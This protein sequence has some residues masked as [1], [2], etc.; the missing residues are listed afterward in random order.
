MVLER[1]GSSG[2]LRGYTNAAYHALS[3]LRRT[4]V[5]QEKT[6]SA[7]STRKYDALEA[8]KLMCEESSESVR[9]VRQLN[10]FARMLVDPPVCS[11]PSTSEDIST[12]RSELT[13][14]SEATSSIDPSASCADSAQATGRET[15]EG[16]APITATSPL[17]SVSTTSPIMKTSFSVPDIV[18]ISPSEAQPLLQ[19][20]P[21]SEGGFSNGCPGPC[22]AFWQGVF[23]GGRT[24][25]RAGV[26]C[27]HCH[28]R[29]HFPSMDW[30]RQNVGRSKHARRILR[31]GASSDLG[32]VPFNTCPSLLTASVPV[33]TP[34]TGERTQ[35]VCPM[36]DPPV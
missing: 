3:I 34:E 29:S 11:T 2:Q 22:L 9:S 4:A 10:S 26:S 1:K 13:L 18:T 30:A 23:S 7:T 36:N 8:H 27:N 12:M 6:K 14:L 17:V 25:C 5:W 33:D 21:F 32:D 16:Q 24:H 19:V 35:G 15:S 20:A 28:D 31:E